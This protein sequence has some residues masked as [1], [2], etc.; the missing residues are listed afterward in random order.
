[1][2]TDSSK[3]DQLGSAAETEHKDAVT[4]S[5][6]EEST[7]KAQPLDAEQALQAAIEQ[8]DTATVNEEEAVLGSSLDLPKDEVP[9]PSTET[10]EKTDENQS[11]QNK[12]TFSVYYCV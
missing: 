7:E 8:P 3:Q 10:N 12:G 4:D 1:M 11:E 2:E 5:V 9:T 6:Q